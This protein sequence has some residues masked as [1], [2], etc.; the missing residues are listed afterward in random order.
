MSNSFSVNLKRQASIPPQL[1]AWSREITQSR[2]KVSI[3]FRGERAQLT[4]TTGSTIEP[5]RKS[6]VRYITGDGADCAIVST[7]QPCWSIQSC[8]IHSPKATRQR[9]STPPRDTPTSLRT[10]FA[11][12]LK[13]QQMRLRSSR[14]GAKRGETKKKNCSRADD[15]FCVAAGGRPRTGCG[16]GEEF[17][18]QHDCATPESAV[19]AASGR[20][21][22]CTETRMATR[23]LHSSNRNWSW[24]GTG[25]LHMTIHSSEFVRVEMR[26][27]LELPVSFPALH[28][29]V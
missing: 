25:G 21:Y 11:A 9:G 15:P 29:R 8:P 1:G 4:Q 27:I 5:E 20:Q 26:R 6:C 14:R 2:R 13:N 7:R 18:H 22:A 10:T 12:N 24:A 16:G 28:A 17:M 3:P 23:P 19:S